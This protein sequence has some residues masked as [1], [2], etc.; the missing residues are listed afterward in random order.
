MQCAVVVIAYSASPSAEEIASYEQCLSILGEH[1]LLL[2]C[3]ESLD[4]GIYENLAEKHARK[5]AAVRFPDASFQSVATYN[6]LM[7][8]VDFYAR[9]TR[10]EYILIYQLDAWVF[11]D[12]LT[13]WCNKGYAY[14][15]APFFTD[16]GETLSFAGNGG[17]SLRRVKNFLSILA[18]DTTGIAWDYSFFTIQI[19][20]KN[21]FRMRIK[22]LLHIGCMALCRISPRWFCSHMPGNEDMLYSRTLSLMDKKNVPPPEIA[23]SFAFERFPG[24]SY[25]MTGETLPFG[26]HAYRRYGENF[27]K[28]PWKT[29]PHE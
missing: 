17:F 25:V 16:R 12:A 23:V 18:G 29:P 14:I 21:R 5:I 2:A 3:P 10:Y 15:G 11:C 7:L 26:C 1:P 13:F 24:K 6:R 4:I 19:P 22:Q 20:A 27:E 28:F 8:N 9:F